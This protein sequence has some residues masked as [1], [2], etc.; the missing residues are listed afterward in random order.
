MRV[1]H[2]CSTLLPDSESLELKGK[3]WER[4]QN[5][6]HVSDTR[7]QQEET[8]KKIPRNAW[9]LLW[10]FHLFMFD[11]LVLLHPSFHSWRRRRRQSCFMFVRHVSPPFSYSFFP[12][13]S[14]FDVA[15]L[16][17]FLSLIS[18]AIVFDPFLPLLKFTL[19]CPPY[20]THVP[21]R[22]TE[23][24][25]QKSWLRKWSEEKGMRRKSLNLERRGKEE[26]EKRKR[27]EK[28]EGEKRS[29]RQKE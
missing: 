23:T 8:K 21:C 4:E 10:Y 28:E 6:R 18:I 7:K 19:R 13:T 12:S 3:C 16:F 2:S 17:F 5:M 15:S 25:M 22:E 26:E 9:I 14:V 11:I 27:R 1:V 20:S 24:F 29:R